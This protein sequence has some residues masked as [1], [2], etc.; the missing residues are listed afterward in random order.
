M[1]DTTMP[2][3]NTRIGMIR[4][5]DEDEETPLPLAS[6]LIPPQCVRGCMPALITTQS[7]IGIDRLTGRIST[8]RHPGL[9]RKY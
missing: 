2:S 6:F 5:P 7:S 1:L 4:V 8:F 3:N 9:V